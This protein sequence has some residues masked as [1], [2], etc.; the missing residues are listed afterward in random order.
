MACAAG[1]TCERW[2]CLSPTPD[3][4]GA[5]SD[6]DTDS[7]PVVDDA[8][9]PCP[10]NYSLCGATCVNLATDPA[11]CGACGAACGPT[12]MCIRAACQ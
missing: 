5:D 10:Q 11:N 2:T 7:G 12:Q 4:A 6:A 1:D 3:D 9:T 8:L